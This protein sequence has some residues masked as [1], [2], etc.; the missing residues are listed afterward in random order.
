GG[1]PFTTDVPVIELR[2]RAPVEITTLVAMDNNVLIDDPERLRFSNTDPL[3]FEVLLTL[4]N[5]AHTIT[6]L[7]FGHDGELIDSVSMQVTV[8]TVAPEIIS[9]AP[10]AVLRG[11]TV[12]IHAT[13]LHSGTQVWFDDA[14]ATSIDRSGLPESIAAVVPDGVGPGQVAVVVGTESGPRSAAF[15]IEVSVAGGSFVRGDVDGDTKISIA[16]PVAILFHL[17]RGAELV[18]EDAADLNDDGE[19]NVT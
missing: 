14:P 15:E 12:T 8:E 5:G 17:F 4:S 9:V 7:G 6:I 13:G 18:C 11:E 16:D 10:G 2:G 19:I 1:Q 3:G